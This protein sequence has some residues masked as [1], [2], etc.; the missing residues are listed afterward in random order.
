V[1]KEGKVP[2]KATITVYVVRKLDWEYSDEYYFTVGGLELRAFRDPDKAEAYRRE[3][4]RPVRRGEAEGDLDN[5]F[6]AHG[7][8]VEEQSSL[9]ADRFRDALRSHGIDPPYDDNFYSWWIDE[10]KRL[11]PEQREVVWDLCDQVHLF[12]VVEQEIEVQG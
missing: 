10:G 9:E 1:T 7:T 2:E 3:L 4:E 6:T 11:P 12:E 5:P 8:R